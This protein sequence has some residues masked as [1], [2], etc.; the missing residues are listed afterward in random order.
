M[1]DPALVR[2]QVPVRRALVSVYDKTGLE[3]LVRG[4]HD[5]GVELV[6][7]GG[8]AALIAGLGLPG[9]QGRGP[10]RLPRVPRR[11]GQDA[12]PAGARRH[13]GRPPPRVP[14]PA[15][16]GARGRALRPG[17]LQPLPVHARPSRPAPRPTSASSRSTSAVRRWSGPRPRTTPASRSSPRPSAYADVLARRRRRRLHPRR[18]AGRWPPRRSSTPRR[19]TCT[20]RAG[21]ATCSPTPPRG[22]ASRR[23]WARRGTSRRCCATARTRTS[24]AALYAS[25]F[26]ARA[27]PGAGRAAARQGD[28]LQQLRRR[29]RGPPGGVRLRPSRPSRSSSTPTRAASPSA[30]TSPRRTARRTSA[31]RCRPS[32]A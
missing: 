22:P 20:W 28:V 4:L 26:V 8:S 1:S 13:P 5:A 24:A 10:H 16:R 27:G 2:D 31:T 25:G 3:E 12:A 19:T 14:R 18:A 32:A 30:P 9:H 15:A 23:G 17:R 11:P 21:W 7:T 29:R 6:S